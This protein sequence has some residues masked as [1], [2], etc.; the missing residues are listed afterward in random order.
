MTVLETV[1]PGNAPKPHPVN[2]LGMLVMAVVNPDGT[3][4]AGTPGGPSGPSTP[5]T[6]TDLSGSIGTG[7]SSQQLA[8]V[9]PAGH[10]VVVT[11]TSSSELRINDAGEA[12]ASLGD[13]VPPGGSWRTTGYP[14]PITNAVRIWGAATGQTFHATRRLTGA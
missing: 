6:V 10:V 14:N 7:G 5:G 12:S 9:A 11:N 4:I 1:I 3:P 8:A 13:A 2:A